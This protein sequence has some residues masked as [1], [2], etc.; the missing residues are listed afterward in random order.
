MQ[1]IPDL[2]EKVHCDGYNYSEKGSRSK[3]LTTN[4]EGR[5]EK[6]KYVQEEVRKERITEISENIASLKETIKFLQLQK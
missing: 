2:Q 6:R 3:V 4:E 5:R 1:V